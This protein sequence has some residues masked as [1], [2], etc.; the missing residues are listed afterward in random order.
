MGFNRNEYEPFA[1]T[2]EFLKDVPVKTYEPSITD[3]ITLV[4][5]ETGEKIF[6]HPNSDG[7]GKYRWYPSSKKLC[8]GDVKG[9]MDKS[10]TDPYFNSLSFEE[11]FDHYEFENGKPVG[12]KSMSKEES[13]FLEMVKNHLSIDTE[14]E[15]SYGYG[16]DSDST[17]LKVKLIFKSDNGRTVEISSSEVYI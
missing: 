4:N 15:T 10:H 6:V 5:R 9:Y 2:A 7:R 14:I 16:S 8:Y 1:D 11:L 17:T 3:G 12:I 13:N